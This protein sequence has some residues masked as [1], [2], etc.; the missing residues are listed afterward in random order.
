V[1]ARDYDLVGFGIAAVDDIVQLARFPDRDTKVPITSIERH[2]GGQCTTALV[3]ASRQGLRCAYAGVLGD[4]DLS[5]F[6][7]ET[8]R[9][10]HVE[11]FQ[12]RDDPEVR[13]YYSIVLVDSS[14]GERTL[15]FSGSGVRGPA[16][17]EISEDL[18]ARSHMLFVDQL[19]PAG[20]LC[21]CRLARKWGTQVIADFERAD[22]GQLREAMLMTDHLIVPFRLAREIT[23]YCDAVAAVTELAR[24]GRA[25]TAV[26]DGRN[27]CWFVADGIGVTHQASL[28]VE[29]VDTTGCG[30]VFHG[31]YA[32]A[33]LLQA[34]PANAIRYAAAAAAL[35]A[36][37]RGAQA[38]IPARAAVEAFLAQL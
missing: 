20:T 36:T 31:A 15:L 10:E 32:A 13:P 33:I 6:T 29:V 5:G 25:C 17:E 35:K 28:P 27:G 26:T 34:T 14:T 38:G 21:A 16:P 3:A 8:L 22:D 2:G 9:R 24:P 19:G 12:M 4:D 1:K 30:D 37:R 7:R 11:V 18:I 23:G